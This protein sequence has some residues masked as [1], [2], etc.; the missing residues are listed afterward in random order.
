MARNH[1]PTHLYF[2]PKPWAGKSPEHF[3][4]IRGSSDKTLWIDQPSW[5]M[6]TSLSLT[7]ILSP[8][9]WGS[10]LPLICLAHSSSLIPSHTTLAYSLLS[11]DPHQSPLR[12]NLNSMPSWEHCLI[13]DPMPCYSLTHLSFCAWSCVGLHHLRI[14]LGL[15]KNIQLDKTNSIL[16]LRIK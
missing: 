1:L 16:V 10:R 14:S 8:S 6:L 11:P 13:S 5:S 4:T 7:R 15:H 3:L 12:S 2:P 9:R